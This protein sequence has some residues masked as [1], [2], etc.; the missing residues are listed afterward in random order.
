MGYFLLG[1]VLLA[2]LLLCVRAFTTADPGRLA[3]RV[4][5]GGGVL[6]IAAAI[7]L[8]ATGRWLVALP[9]AAMGLS[10]LGIGGGHFAGSGYAPRRPGQRSTVRS[11]WVEMELEHDTGRMNGRIRRGPQAG[12]ELDSLDIEALLDQLAEFDDEESRQL[13]E[14]YLDR[15]TPGWREDG[16]ADPGGRSRGAA[17]GGPMTQNEAYEVLGVTPAAGEADI[18]RAHR[19]LMM[20]MHP[21]RG[22]STYLAAKINEAKD[23]LLRLHRRNS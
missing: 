23:L 9:L 12:V 10:L 14:A 16:E 7:G 22:G 15:R 1:L 8:I 17:A 13:L 4:R 5:K 20:K 3:D 21:D 6:L 2:T 11:A 18:R 19:D